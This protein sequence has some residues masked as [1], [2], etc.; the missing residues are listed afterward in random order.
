M[1]RAATYVELPSNDHLPWADAA[2]AII[3]E[4]RKFVADI[5]QPVKSDRMPSL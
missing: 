5:E 3:S 1:L 2:D 4:I